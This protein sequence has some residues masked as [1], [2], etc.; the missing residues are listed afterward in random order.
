M[1]GAHK[2]NE[3][4]DEHDGKQRKQTISEVGTN[5]IFIGVEHISDVCAAG[6]SMFTDLTVFIECC[7]LLA[8]ILGFA[9]MLFGMAGMLAVLGLSAYAF[10]MYGWTQTCLMQARD[11]K[12]TVIRSCFQASAMRIA[13]LR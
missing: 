9:P 12:M 3:D 8:L 6:V 4:D 13:I 11:N 2:G 10:R 5:I 1:H 7:A